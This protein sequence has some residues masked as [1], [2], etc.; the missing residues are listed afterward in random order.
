MIAAANLIFVELW[1][2]KVIG[3]G[4]F[5]YLIFDLRNSSLQA[6]FTGN[7]LIILNNDGIILNTGGGRSFFSWKQVKVS[8]RPDSE[9]LYL[10]I[11]NENQSESEFSQ[12]KIETTFLS[13][14]KYELMQYIR[15]YIGRYDRNQIAH[16]N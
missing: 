15:V 14:D 7:P 3:V 11:E 8:I 10:R 4:I 1:L 16:F 9:H 6:F 2:M 12:I 13:V 5:L